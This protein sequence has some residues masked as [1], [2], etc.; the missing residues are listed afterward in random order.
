M[1]VPRSPQAD[2]LALR[3]EATLGVRA[4]TTIGGMSESYASSFRDLTLGAFV[5]ELASGA[6]VPGG[7]SASAVGAS[8]GAAL[9]CLAHDAALRTRLADGA[10]RRAEALFSR[11]RMVR[12][13]KDVVETVVREPERLDEYLAD[14]ARPSKDVAR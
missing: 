11:E 4:A 12:A 6:P 1:P 2:V 13:F 5:D 10:R 9:R 14:V 7:G 3:F 8:L